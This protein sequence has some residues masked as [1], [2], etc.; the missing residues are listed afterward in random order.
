[1]FN[2][3]NREEEIMSPVSLEALAMCG[4][5]YTDVNIDVEEYEKFHPPPHLLAKP[6][7]KKTSIFCSSPMLFCGNGRIYNVLSDSDDHGDY[8]NFGE[9]KYLKCDGKEKRFARGL[10]SLKFFVKDLMRKIFKIFRG[11]EM[12]R[13]T[14]ITF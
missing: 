1:M 4:A 14:S 9:M 12:R 8:D 7:K 5:N 2:Q 11:K 10:R 3:L 13:A 6:K